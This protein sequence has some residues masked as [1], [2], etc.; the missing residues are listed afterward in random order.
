MAKATALRGDALL[1]IGIG[2]DAN[3][4]QGAEAVD[5]EAE[6]GA[7]EAARLLAAI[8]EADAADERGEGVEADV[9]MQELHQIL[10]G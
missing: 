4:S 3:R 6:L 10:R 8:D 7:E 2:N 9:V 5:I 1:S